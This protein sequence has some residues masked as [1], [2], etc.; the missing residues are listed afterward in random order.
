LKLFQEVK[1]PD[2]KAACRKT[3]E[4]GCG[5]WRAK[6]GGSPENSKKGDNEIICGAS[7]RKKQVKKKSFTIMFCQRGHRNRRVSTH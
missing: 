6:D 3:G 2:F 4:K 1:T 5:M 7:L